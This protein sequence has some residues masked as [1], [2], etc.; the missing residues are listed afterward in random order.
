MTAGW[1]GWGDWPVV[2]ATGQ[3]VA[4]TVPMGGDGM[5]QWQTSTS[6]GLLPMS[7]H[8][9]L[10][11][12]Q[13]YPR[14]V[15]M[16]LVAT[17]HLWSFMWLL[18]FRSSYGIFYAFGSS[19]VLEAALLWIFFSNSNTPDRIMI[20]TLG[21]ALAGTL[22]FIRTIADHWWATI[23]DKQ[24]SRGVEM[25]RMG[26][27]CSRACVSRAGGARK[28]AMRIKGAEGW[29]IAWSISS[30]AA[31]LYAVPC[32]FALLRQGVD[33]VL[34]TFSCHLLFFTLGECLF[35]PSASVSVHSSAQSL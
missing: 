14:N 5:L 13:N 10:E 21:L 9:F 23:R 4:P 19:I 12:N 20:Q 27:G 30:W 1:A 11:H 2:L 29:L 33:P 7:L 22:L 3:N 28:E 16:L 17:T 15:A 32:M 24:R 8:P 35:P 18:L 6:K 25:E 34:A 26:G 31:L